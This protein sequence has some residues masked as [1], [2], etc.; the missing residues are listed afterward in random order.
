MGVKKGR[1]RKPAAF[2]DAVQVRARLP[3]PSKE[4]DGGALADARTCYQGDAVVGE[5][6]KVNRAEHGPTGDR[7]SSC[8]GVL[9]IAMSGAPCQPPVYIAARNRS[10]AARYGS[11]A[12]P[13]FGVAGAAVRVV[14]VFAALRISAARSRASAMV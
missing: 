5:P 4:Y 6:A 9:R 2:S 3:L 7:R 14:A 10:R 11:G 1:R 13:S 12:V 8:R